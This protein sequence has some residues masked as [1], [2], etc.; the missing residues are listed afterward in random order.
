MWRVRRR[1]GNDSLRFNKLRRKC[2][3]DM[4]A[5][6]KDQAAHA[7]SSPPCPIAVS[8]SLHTSF[9]SAVAATANHHRSQ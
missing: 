9:R 4:G 5:G 8:T 6:A 7:L 2:N 3:G 1:R